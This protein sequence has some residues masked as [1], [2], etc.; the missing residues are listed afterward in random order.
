VSLNNLLEHYLFK[1]RYV[2]RYDLTLFEED[3]NVSFFSM[4]DNKVIDILRNSDVHLSTL[5]KQR[6]SNPAWVF[7]YYHKK[8][9]IYG[10]SFL[11]I[12]KK[13]EWNDSLP[14]MPGEARLGSNYV[15][16]QYRGRKIRGSICRQQINYAKKNNLDLWCVI[17]RSNTASLRAESKYCSI[18]TNNFLIK[19]YARNV[20]SIITNQL[21]IYLL[22]GERRARR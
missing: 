17:E 20:I 7:F 18:K 8:N 21:R 15:Y 11:H 19:F 12:P 1:R 5:L 10:Y 9:E 3:E 4:T 16:P 14:T 13:E 2:F 6:L 22:L